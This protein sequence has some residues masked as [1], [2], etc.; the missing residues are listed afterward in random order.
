MGLYSIILAAGEGKRM[1]S[2][3]AKPLQ[4]AAGKAL[5]EWVLDTAEE[6]GSDENIVVIGHKAEDVKAYLGDRAK[7]AYQ[8]EQLGTGDAVMQG[9]ESI[10]DVDGTVMVLYGDSPLIE[11]ET[12]KR[13]REDHSKKMR[14]ATVITAI[15][16]EPYGYG[17]IVRENG[18]IVRI[19]EQKDASED[20]QKITEV[21][22]GMYFFDIQKLKESLSKITND[23]SQGEYYITDVIEIMLSEGEKVG[24]Y[25]T[26]LEQ[27]MGVNDKLQLSQVGKILNRRK[28][29][30]LMLAGVTIIDPDKVQV[31]TNVKVGRDTVLYPGTVLEGDSVIGENCVIGS[32]TSLN[33]CKVGNNTKILETVGIDSEIG[34]DTNVGPFAYLRPGTKVGSEVKIGDFVEVKNSTIDDGTKV[35]HLTY[36]GDADVGKRVNFGCGTV[37]VNYDGVNKHRTII[38]DDC[39]IGCNTNL[40]SPVVVRHGAYT[41]AGSTITDEVPPESLAIARSKQV[42]KEQWT[43]KRKDSKKK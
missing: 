30:A 13:V 32:N 19:V 12:L 28:V 7:Y 31:T 6:T 41:A 8:Y 27:T 18:E 15:A 16:D 5:V 36:I 25:V 24:A 9:I 11:A 4:Q 26:D 40:V 34:S 14:A 22:S 10:K 43:A 37:V 1:K 29:E 2:N 42:V 39:F 35:A 33:N 17:R 3:I 23:N 21:N 38:E 20:E